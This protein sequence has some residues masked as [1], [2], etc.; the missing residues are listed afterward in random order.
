MLFVYSIVECSLN[1]SDFA[2]FKENSIFSKLL[3]VSLIFYM[4][5]FY[6]VSVTYAVKVYVYSRRHVKGHSL[7]SV[8]LVEA[9]NL[10]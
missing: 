10:D 6:I 2:V 9:E 4:A 7:V 1:G 3:S 5:F 8:R